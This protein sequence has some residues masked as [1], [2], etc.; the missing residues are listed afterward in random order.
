MNDLDK[1]NNCKSLKDRH[2]LVDIMVNVSLI[3]MSE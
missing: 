2:E 3:F 1:I